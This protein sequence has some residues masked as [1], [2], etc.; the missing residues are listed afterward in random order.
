MLQAFEAPGRF[1]RGNIHGHS[2]NSDGRL[3]PEEV[4]RRYRDQGY[5]FIS[6]TDHFRP[7]FNFPVSDTRPYRGNGFTTILGAEVHAPETSGGTEWHILAVGLPADF[8]ATTADETGPTL[9][10]RCAEAGAFVAI[11]HPHWYQLTLEDALSIESAHAVE[12]YNHTCAVNADRADGLVMLDSLLTAG[13]RLNAIAVDDSHWKAPDAFGGW[14]MVKAEENDPDVLLDALKSGEFYASQ[15]PEFHDIRIDGDDLVVR[16]STAVSI[17]LLGSVRDSEVAHG[18]ALTGARLPLKKFRGAWCRA[19]IVD[20]SGRRAWS[21]P[22]W[23][24]GN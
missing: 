17:M 21:N 16:S 2:T 3:D 24:D 12:V 5:D 6:L 23:L 15:G 20:A 10:R 19:V 18:E 22:L 9:A 8:P 13:R 1:W 7:N 11:A 14:V 4:C